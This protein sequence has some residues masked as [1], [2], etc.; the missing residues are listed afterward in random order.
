[1]GSHKNRAASTAD[2]AVPPTPDLIVSGE[3]TPNSTG[4]YYYA[5]MYGGEQYYKRADSAYYIF[6]QSEIESY[7]IHHDLGSDV[8]PYHYS[9][10]GELIGSYEPVGEATGTAIVSA[11]S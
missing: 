10:T 6:W 8:E 9:T 4:N 2:N 3:I 1:M 7:L 11:G 5:G